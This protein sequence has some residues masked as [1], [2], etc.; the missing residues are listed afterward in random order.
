MAG[1]CEPCYFENVHPFANGANGIWIHRGGADRNSMVYM[2]HISGDGNIDSLIRITTS[3]GAGYRESYLING[4]K[5]ECAAGVQ[6]YAV[7]LDMGGSPIAINGLSHGGAACD[8]GSAAIQIVSSMPRLT[9]TAVDIYGAGVTNWMTDTSTGVYT[10]PYAQDTSWGISGTLG[11]SSHTFPWTASPKA[12]NSYTKGAT[13]Y[14]TSTNQLKTCIDDGTPAYEVTSPAAVSG[15]GVL[16][17]ATH[18]WLKPGDD[19][20]T[21][22]TALN[23]AIDAANTDGWMYVYGG[24]HTVGTDPLTCSG[25]SSTERMHV[26]CIGGPVGKNPTGDG[27]G[28]KIL[29]AGTAGAHPTVETG[30]ASWDGF[31]VLAD[32]DAQDSAMKATASVT[33][34]N[35]AMANPDSS[36]NPAQK[37]VLMVSAPGAT[38]T[39]QIENNYFYMYCS[40]ADTECNRESNMVVVDLSKTGNKTNNALVQGNTF[41]F[42]GTSK[43]SASAKAAAFSAISGDIITT[44]N[45]TYHTLLG[46]GAAPANHPYAYY[47]ANISNVYQWTHT[48]EWFRGAGQF[49]AANPYGTQAF[50]YQSGGSGMKDLTSAFEM[51]PN[52]VESAV[53]QTNH[54]GETLPDFQIA[55]DGDVAYWPIADDTKGCYTK[56]ESSTSDNGTSR[57]GID[58][59]CTS[60]GGKPTF[61]F[62]RFSAAG[63]TN[64]CGPG[65]GY[66]AGGA[67]AT[68]L[69]GDTYFDTTEHTL[70]VCSFVGGEWAFRRVDG[71]GNCST[72]VTTT[73]TTTVAPTTTTT[74]TLP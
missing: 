46:D 71:A 43:S 27:S 41:E 39:A 12:C 74:T 42:A 38:N 51:F 35:S 73:T 26:V 24:T 49:E 8:A 17:D 14:D 5:S 60:M 15:T 29:P 28:C 19:F 61:H 30:W 2:N 23:S 67:D 11:L 54:R 48:N 63:T 70:C 32:D 16:A 59:S 40:D 13:Y 20:Q 56:Q 62:A 10:I 45:N 18:V 34:T 22:C 53:L 55:R 72:P 3:G 69:E 31:Y 58:E 25:V 47:F 36:N 52:N 57:W 37:N 68:G 33:V 44:Q 4:V 21:A 64:R 1:G 7:S 66:N 9:W 50:F 65:A 6:P